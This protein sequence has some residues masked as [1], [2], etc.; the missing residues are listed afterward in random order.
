VQEAINQV[1]DGVGGEIAYDGF[2]NNDK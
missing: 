1:M 2:Y